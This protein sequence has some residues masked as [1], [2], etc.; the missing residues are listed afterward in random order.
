MKTLMHLA[1]CAALIITAGCGSQEAPQAATS[2][3]GSDH[4]HSHGE[5][6][7]HSHDHGPNHGV[8]APFQLDQA[9]AGVL[10]LKLHDDKGDL[11]LWL[12][13][14][15]GP[16][17]LPLDAVITAS[18]PKLDKSVELRVRNTEKNDDE[19]GNATVR[20]G[21]TNYFIF[22]GDSGVDP[23]FLVGKEFA[24][25]VELSFSADGKSYKTEAFM[26]RPHQH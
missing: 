16:F 15:K 3:P 1:F 20:D 5:D 13:A 21:K 19:G 2:E 4:G 6:S 23:A 8:L 7:D 10:E 12:T 26:L 25:E 24:S 9:K 22:P 11:E 14:G 18:F 17:D